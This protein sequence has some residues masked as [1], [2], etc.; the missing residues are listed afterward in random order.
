MLHL[1]RRLR[2]TYKRLIRSYPAAMSQARHAIR[3]HVAMSADRE[4]ADD[5][6]GARS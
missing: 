5:R 1:T 2:L 6:E 3:D 4:T